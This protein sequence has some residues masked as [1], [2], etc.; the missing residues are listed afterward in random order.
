MRHVNTIIKTM[1]QKVESNTLE[2]DGKISTDG[3]IV[4]KRTMQISELKNKPK[5]KKLT[6]SIAKRRY[7]RKD[8]EL[9]DRPK[10][11]QPG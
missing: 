11:I 3:E 5:K 2:T 8:S 9:D 6:S 10:E 4:Y 7:P 1:S